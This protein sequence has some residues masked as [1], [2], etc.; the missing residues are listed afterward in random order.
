MSRSDAPCVRTGAPVATVPASAAPSVATDTAATSVD[1]D[2][3]GDRPADG[4]VDR[5]APTL[6]LRTVLHLRDMTQ[7]ELSWAA[8]IGATRLS[9]ILHQH[10]RPPG[11]AEKRRIAEALSLDPETLFPGPCPDRVRA[12]LARVLGITRQDLTP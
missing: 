12:A 9:Q 11:P 4:P 2:R 5:L 7:N 8:R 1:A 6:V 10:C 3:P